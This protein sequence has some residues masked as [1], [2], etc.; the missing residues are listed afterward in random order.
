MIVFK[1][2]IEII[3]F[4]FSKKRYVEIKETNRRRMNAL[5]HMKRLKTKKK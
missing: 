1:S 4:R 2:N 5:K 3:L